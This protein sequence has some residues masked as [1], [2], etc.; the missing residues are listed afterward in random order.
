MN[1]K[2]MVPELDANISSGN[3]IN[4]L[5]GIIIS[6]PEQIKRRSLNLK[7]AHKL[8][9][10]YKNINLS[11]L[12]FKD[13]NDDT[14]YYTYTRKGKT[15]YKTVEQ[16]IKEADK[17]KEYYKKHRPKRARTTINYPLITDDDILDNF[18]GIYNDIEKWKD[19]IDYMENDR[20]YHFYDSYIQYNKFGVAIWLPKGPLNKAYMHDSAVFLVSDHIS[21]K[22]SGEIR[23]RTFRD[24]EKKKIRTEIAKLFMKIL[25]GH[26]VLTFENLLYHVM[27]YTYNYVAIIQSKLYTYNIYK[28]C[29]SLY[30]KYLETGEIGIPE[31]GSDNKAHHKIFY[32]KSEK[33]K[34]S[35]ETQEYIREY[36]E[37]KR[38]IDIDS[39][40]T[41]LENVIRYCKDYGKPLTWQNIAYEYSRQL[42]KV[43]DGKVQAISFPT[44][45]RLYK[46][47]LSRHNA[48]VLTD[49][50]KEQL[51]AEYEEK[52]NYIENIKVHTLKEEQN[53]HNPTS[54]K[55]F[56]NPIIENKK[57]HELDT[58]RAI[59]EARTSIEKADIKTERKQQERSLWHNILRD[60]ISLTYKTFIEQYPEYKDSVTENAFKHTK[61]K[62]KKKYGR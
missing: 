26:N 30:S 24:K 13:V 46:Q 42:N 48:Y 2:N 35:K 21:H 54:D 20:E 55:D 53:W 1:N 56:K 31:H 52:R 38:N 57:K 36:K 11:K 32:Y 5:N 59:Y 4:S 33:I 25:N 15:M 10:P 47:L 61:T 16:Y 7:I 19:F 62:L 50:E 23:K 39:K 45:Q 34:N 43:K 37:S 28:A 41:I 14:V 44:Y 17:R 49:A 6:D 9:A 29:E 18:K 58:L 12:Q 51:K 3:T 8:L 22:K 40:I 27:K 60:N